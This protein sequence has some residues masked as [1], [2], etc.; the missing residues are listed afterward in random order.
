MTTMPTVLHRDVENGQMSR[1][2]LCKLRALRCR[3]LFLGRIVRPCIGLCSKPVLTKKRCSSSCHLLFCQILPC[4]IACVLL[5]A[6]PFDTARRP[7]GS[8]PRTFRNYAF[9]RNPSNLSLPWVFVIQQSFHN[10]DAFENSS[11]PICE[12]QGRTWWNDC[13]CVALPASWPSR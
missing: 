1:F 13:W 11:M 2:P 9:P 5:R 3:C 6:C 10:I 8:A 7:R 12:F 4:R